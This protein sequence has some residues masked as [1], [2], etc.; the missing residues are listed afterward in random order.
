[1]ECLFMR[2]SRS[3]AEAICAF[4]ESDRQTMSLGGNPMHKVIIALAFMSFGASTA[5]FALP[6]DYCRELDAACKKECSTYE[7]VNKCQDGFEFCLLFAHQGK[8][9]TFR[10]AATTV[11]PFSPPAM[12]SGVKSVN[13]GTAATTT[14]NIGMGGSRAINPG[15]AATTTISA[16]PSSAPSKPPSAVSSG[17][18]P[19]APIAQSGRGNLRI[20]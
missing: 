11:G 12:T 6:P 1:M 14:A 19:H 18:A 4:S 17:V 5:A 16:A 20:Q 3:R 10:G 2:Q 9:P 8:K 7:C 13:P 15:T